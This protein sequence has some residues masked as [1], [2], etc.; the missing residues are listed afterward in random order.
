MRWNRKEELSNSNGRLECDLFLAD[1]TIPGAGIGLFSGVDKAA[2]DTIG[3]GD[4]AIP[5]VDAHW[6]NGHRFG[7]WFF[8]PTADYVWDGVGMG[9]RLE[10][11]DRNDI[12][13]FWPGIDAMVNA[14]SGLLNLVKSTPVYD[15]GGVHRSR[16]P[17]AGSMSPYEASSHGS[18]LAQRDIPAGGELFKS[19]GDNWFLGREHLGQIPL[20][21]HYDAAYK[22]AAT[23]KDG[24]GLLEIPPDWIYDDYVQPVKTIWN[25]RTLNAFQDFSWD[26]IDRVVEAYDFGVLLQ[27]TATRPLDWLHEH[28]RCLDHIV[29]G[30]STIDGAG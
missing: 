8:N 11:F 27:D 15:Q 20:L 5:L 26:D 17:G 23:L 10:L 3:N 4:K 29:H 14:H 13:A 24:S 18:S 22:L 16:H 28:G 7:T 19:Y 1:S 25:S 21:E 6:H 2:G 9:M 30:R 12:S